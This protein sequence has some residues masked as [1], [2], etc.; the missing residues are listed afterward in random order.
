[1][2]I[3]DEQRAAVRAE[4]CAQLGHDL[5]ITEAIRN[6]RGIGDPDKRTMNVRGKDDDTVPHLRCTRCPKVWLIMPGV[7]GYDGAE[8]VLN[9][10]LAPKHRR[11]LRRERR[12]ERL[13][14]EEAEAKRLAD[15]AAATSLQPGQ[16]L[17]PSDTASAPTPA[18]TP[19][20]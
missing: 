5:D 6:D 11:K 20:P 17:A 14:A 15:E 7:D 3:S 1:V 10:Q 4:L 16:P 18:P 13:D 9:D 19:A 12:R 8:D 2:E